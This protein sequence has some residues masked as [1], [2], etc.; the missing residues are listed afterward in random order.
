MENHPKMASFLYSSNYCCVIW[1]ETYNKDVFNKLPYFHCGVALIDNFT[2]QSKLFEFIL[3][4]NTYQ[5]AIDSIAFSGIIFNL[6]DK[7][8]GPI[9]LV[10]EIPP[11]IGAV[12]PSLLFIAFATYLLNKRT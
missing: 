11:M 2:G 12:I 10:Y 5:V 1:I 7:I 3:H 9:V 8:F 4:I 6:T